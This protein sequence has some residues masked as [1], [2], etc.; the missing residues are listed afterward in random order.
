MV[1]TGAFATISIDDVSIG[2][3][4]ADMVDRY[5]KGT[6]VSEIPAV[7]VSDFVTLFNR[8]SAE[9]IGVKIPEEFLKNSVLV[10]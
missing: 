1:N 10:D 4:T 7:V 2:A 9:T 6:P 5:L 3:R 8:A